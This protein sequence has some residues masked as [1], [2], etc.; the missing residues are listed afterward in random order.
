MIKQSPELC[1]VDALL[2]GAVAIVL[3]L[4][5]EKSWNQWHNKK[6]CT[7]LSLDTGSHIMRLESQAPSSADPFK[8]DPF[9]AKPQTPAAP[10]ADSH[11]ALKDKDGFSAAQGDLIEKHSAIGPK[12]AEV[13]E[14]AGVTTLKELS[15]RNPEHLATALNQAN[16]KYSITKEHY[17][18]ATVQKWVDEAK[19]LVGKEI[20]ANTDPF[21][22]KPSQPSQHHSSGGTA[23]VDPFKPQQPSQKPQN[24]NGVDPFKPGNGSAVGVDPFKPHPN[25]SGSFEQPVIPQETENDRY[26]SAQR[27]YDP[28]RL[29]E[30]AVDDS[31]RV[32]AA[33]AS[34]RY[35]AAATLD[36]LAHD[37]YPEIRLA[38]AGN[39]ATGAQTLNYLSGSADLRVLDVL[40]QRRELPYEALSK[41][42][43]APSSTVRSRVALNAGLP[44]QL[45]QVLAGD[46]SVSVRRTLLQRQDLPSSV[47]QHMAL[48][49]DAGIQM[50][51]LQHRNTDLS[52]LNELLR[53]DNPHLHAGVAAHPQ[54]TGN[55]LIQLAQ[56]Q[57]PEVAQAVVKNPHAPE[58]AL[59]F[60]ARNHPELRLQAVQHPH[61][62]QKL[63]GMLL[64]DEDSRV[65]KTIATRTSSE[66]QLAQLAAD[67]SEDIRQTVAGR[68]RT[69][70]TLAKLVG[71]D[72]ASVRQQVVNNAA[73]TAEVL[74]KLVHD[75]L[76]S[77]RKQ[78]ATHAA[79]SPQILAQLA[80]DEEPAVQEVVAAQAKTP[81]SSLMQ[82][83][84][85]PQVE[86]KLALLSNP[87]LNDRLRE[88]VLA[89]GSS[90]EI[91][92]KLVNDSQTP[93]QTLAQI[94]EAAGKHKAGDDAAQD[95]A[96]DAVRQ[97]LIYHPHSDDKIVQAVMA[98]DLSPS[99]QLA[100]AD[101]QQTPKLALALLAA[102]ADSDQVQQRLILNPALPSEQ[103]NTI[104][105]KGLE[106]STQLNL[107]RQRQTPLPVLKYL[108]EQA[109]Q[110]DQRLA[111]VRHPKADHQIIA[112]V[113]QA[114]LST[115][116]KQSL[117]ADVSLKPLAYELLSKDAATHD[118]LVLNQNV[119]AS[120]LLNIAKSE[121]TSEQT[122][123][124]TA[125]HGHADSEVLNALGRNGKWP[126]RYAAAKHHEQLSSELAT[127]L[128]HDSNSYVKDMANDDKPFWG[129]G[130][131]QNGKLE[132]ALKAEGLNPDELDQL[133]IPYKLTDE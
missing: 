78:V 6:V 35:A 96:F 61:A 54:A 44:R 16:D 69:V 26:Y 7:S 29:A 37:P 120:A 70:S 33:V 31:P 87:K 91:L 83:A 65:R 129:T 28:H 40:S 82:L 93:T 131:Y 5:A 12:R 15:R 80:Q 10:A 132:K 36:R 85:A 66:S 38:V 77:I 68:T 32:R 13:L 19:E 90:A 17:S 108:A 8:K 52:V 133:H 47:L 41:L 1:P 110:E 124:L 67:G 106:P 2:E 22:G 125:F 99:T 48:D 79:V 25:N 71:D 88:A 130:W 86:V 59:G 60:V 123:F 127:K 111:L 121:Q 49:P 63:F 119:P 81:E 114:P 117:A 72:S 102:R 14:K 109:T 76:K 30:L 75:P 128:K 3:A 46:D 56:E 74:G 101:N 115:A 20:P 89:S 42:I 103:L 107:A 104:L 55:L 24:P 105:D 64:Q 21:A 4:M 94:A 95:T 53:H 58:E 18:T 98:Q 122:R 34:N 73:A 112:Q 45:M 62:G 23:G 116:G 27:S 39:A 50:G 9:A 113:L 11:T 97:G 51:V 100:L 84:Q 43:Y 126:L 92:R 118:K 57:N